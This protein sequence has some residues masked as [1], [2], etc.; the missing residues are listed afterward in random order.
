M[1][2][3][4]DECDGVIHE[5]EEFIQ[6][7]GMNYCESCFDEHKHDLD[8]DEEGI[9]L[10]CDC[11]GDSITSGYYYRF[12]DEVLCMEC[13]KSNKRTTTVDEL[14]GDRDDSF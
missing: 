2:F 13:V 11:C 10:V 8:I 7:M 6:F 5:Y 1:S 12:D 4:C 14:R 9:E 3:I